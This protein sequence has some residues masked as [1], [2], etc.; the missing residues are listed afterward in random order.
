GYDEWAIKAEKRLD[1]MKLAALMM[2]DRG[3]PPQAAVQFVVQQA[4]P[5]LKFDNHQNFV[6]FYNDW[7]LSDEYDDADPVLQQA[8]EAVVELHEQAMAA[9]AQQQMARQRSVTEPFQQQD[10]MKALAMAQLAQGGKSGKSG[11]QSAQAGGAAAQSGQG[12][13]D[14]GP[15]A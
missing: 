9:R 6:D 14:D 1:D 10:A 3:V 5:N 13:Q 12:Q 4:A 7:Y 11:G 2:R 15:D 8:L